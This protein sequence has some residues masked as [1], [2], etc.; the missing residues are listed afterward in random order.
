MHY[1]KIKKPHKNSLLAIVTAFSLFTV[2]ACSTSEAPEQGQVNNKASQ[3]P[4]QTEPSTSEKKVIAKGTFEGK[5]DH[6]TSGGV[7]IVESNGKYSIQLA[8]DFSLDSAP[9]PKVGLGKDGY[10]PST[11]AGHLTSLKGASAYELAEGTNI[12]DYNEV[13]IWCEKF[14][15]P[16]GVAKLKSL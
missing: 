9:D 8:D 7:S 6:E 11:K 4:V 5:S 12:G 13:Y 16:L 14:D 1:W 2:V 10:D 15:V 3:T